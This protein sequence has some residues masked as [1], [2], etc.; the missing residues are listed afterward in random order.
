MS[1]NKM[2]GKPFFDFFLNTTSF[3]AVPEKSLIKLQIV[4]S[5]FKGN[6]QLEQ[7]IKDIMI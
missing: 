6:D 2:H 4:L 1:S 3:S 7:L 5:Y